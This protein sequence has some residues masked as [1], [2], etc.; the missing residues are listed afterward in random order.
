MSDKTEVIVDM[1]YWKKL[2]V[3]HTWCKC[4]CKR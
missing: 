2:L 3:V 1:H 4:M